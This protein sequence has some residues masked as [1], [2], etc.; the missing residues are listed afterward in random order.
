[1][2]PIVWLQVFVAKEK[3]WDSAAFLMAESPACV[4]T[5]ESHFRTLKFKFVHIDKPAACVNVIY[6]IIVVDN[7][8]FWCNIIWNHMVHLI[9]G[10][11][12]VLE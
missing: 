12:I 8:D 10:F 11:Q 9:E 7:S 3:S 2:Y 4:P 1:M 6:I 5:L